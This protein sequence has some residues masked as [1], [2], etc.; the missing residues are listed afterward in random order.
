MAQSVIEFVIMSLGS[1]HIVCQV[2]LLGEITLVLG[3]VLS[4]CPLARGF[5]ASSSKKEISSTTINRSQ[6]QYI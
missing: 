3:A 2:I 6:V 5:S 4:A 1:S